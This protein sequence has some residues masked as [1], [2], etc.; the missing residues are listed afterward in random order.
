MSAHLT[1]W[2]DADVGAGPAAFAD[3]GHSCCDIRR[4]LAVVRWPVGAVRARLLLTYPAAATAG[5]RFTFVGPADESLGELRDALRAVPRT[6]YIGV[7]VRGRGCR[8]APAVR[9]LLRDG[10]FALIHSHGLRATAHAVAANV[11]F[12]VPHVAALHEPLPPGRFA[13]LPGRLRRWALARLLRRPDAVAVAGEDARADLLA[14]FPALA[15]RVVAVPD[16]VCAQVPTNG[17]E[18]RRRRTDGRE[19]VVGFLAHFTPDHGFSL[20]L[21]AT[22]RLAADPTAPPFRVAAFW[23]TDGRE[24]ARTEVERRGLCGRVSL[25]DAPADMDLPRAALDLVVAAS[26]SEES[27][28][29]AMEAMAAGVPVLGA[30]AP[31][32]REVLRGT[33]S[34][35][36]AAGDADALRHGLHLALTRPWSEAARDYAPAARARFDGGR[37][38]RRI[39]ELFDRLTTHCWRAS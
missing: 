16:G 27:R 35:T 30:D 15:G 4:V 13:G 14:S 8:M 19:A 1:A 18:R 21:D 31:G 28:L 24:A 32:L 2:A 17:A 12:G 11:G 39:T 34:R 38:A 26:A 23:P 20:L 36:V 5:W 33:P 3:D 6:E 25:R 10:G 37:A 29:A 7:R 9:A 22:Q